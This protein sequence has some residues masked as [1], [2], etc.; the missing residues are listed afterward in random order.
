MRIVLTSIP[1]DA[2]FSVFQEWPLPPSR[3][4]PWLVDVVLQ[5]TAMAHLIF[6]LSYNKTLSCLVPDLSSLLPSS[7]CKQFYILPTLAFLESFLTGV[8][9]NLILA[10]D[11]WLCSLVCSWFWF[12][13][14]GSLFLDSGTGW[15]VSVAHSILWQ[16]L[17]RSSLVLP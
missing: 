2:H 6:N 8:N 15:F 13:L 17:S 10:L 12:C 3:G 14:W 5:S 16:H 9:K 4:P 11:L 1:N 7:L